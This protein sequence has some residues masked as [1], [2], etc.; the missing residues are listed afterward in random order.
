MEDGLDLLRAWLRPDLVTAVAAPTP[1]GPSP[2]GLES[3]FLASLA[4]ARA[5]GA[6][7]VDVQVG[8][9]GA[10]GR[11]TEVVIEDLARGVSLTGLRA[12]LAEGTPPLDPGRDWTLPDLRPP[13]GPPGFALTRFRTHHAGQTIESWAL[14]DGTWEIHLHTG[15]TPGNRETWYLP[16]PDP[17]ETLNRLR[18]ALREGLSPAGPLRVRLQGEPVR[19]DHGHLAPLLDVRRSDDATECRLELVARPDGSLTLSHRG[20]V[21]F[22]GSC[23]IPHLRFSWDGAYHPGSREPGAA[24]AR[25]FEATQ[26]DL[27]ELLVTRLATGELPGEA[28]LHFLAGH[29]DPA[30]RSRPLGR[31]LRGRPFTTQELVEGTALAVSAAATLPPAGPEFRLVDERLW[32][33][34]TLQDLRRQESSPRHQTS[35]AGL[36]AHRLQPPADHPCAGWPRLWERQAARD[37]R[38]AFA[39][40]LAFCELHRPGSGAWPFFPAPGSSEMVRVRV[41]PKTWD[42]HGALWIVVNHPLTARL[43]A[44]CAPDDAVRLLAT[45]VLLSQDQEPSGD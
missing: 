17:A 37:P 21:F 11:F 28:W 4:R 34:A 19:P 41:L 25:D 29:P 22:R 24:V 39:G 10:T 2:Q 38:L 42:L 36:A 43:G 31:D 26:R 35:D 30:W 27:G 33:N 16:I 1:S 23:P 7:D 18:A 12:W 20:L 6:R 32:T 15:S 13:L 45:L 40:G 44:S 3:T 5:F 14:P 8:A 9:D